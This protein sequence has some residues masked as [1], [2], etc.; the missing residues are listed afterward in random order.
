MK[1][2]HGN[3]QKTKIS[4]RQQ[5]QLYEDLNLPMSVEQSHHVKIADQVVI[6]VSS[7]A[8]ENSQLA[9]HIMTRMVAEIVVLTKCTVQ[10]T[11]SVATMDHLLLSMDSASSNKLYSYN[12]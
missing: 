5:I 9:S 12:V 11:K 3:W 6:V 2:L 4:L 1:S 8:V 7:N 10:K